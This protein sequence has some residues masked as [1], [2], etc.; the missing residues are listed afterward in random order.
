M[1]GAAGGAILISAFTIGA[2]APQAGALST[3]QSIDA[4]QAAFTVAA[5][6]ALGAVV[7]ALFVSK[8]RAT[9]DG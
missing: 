3:A 5:I 8:A 4:G 7:G 2:N 9:H 1:A 6:L